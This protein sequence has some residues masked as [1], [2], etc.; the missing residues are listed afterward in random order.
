[1]IDDKTQTYMAV[2]R[3]GGVSGDA[4]D[5]WQVCDLEQ[6]LHVTLP[7]AYKAFLLLAGKWF[8]PFVGSQYIL[9]HDCGELTHDPA[10]L[11]RAGRGILQEDGED[12]PA[13]AFV[14]F[15]HHG[16]ELRFFLLDDGDDPAVYE[17]VEHEPPAQKVAASFSMFVLQQVKG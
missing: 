5:E 10:E 12:L 14:F 3:V 8:E 7:P 1:M 9:E 17:Y 11:Q 16:T 15:K 6:Q 13:G 2:L 4:C